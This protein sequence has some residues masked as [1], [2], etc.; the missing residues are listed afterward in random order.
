M[1]TDAPETKARLELK[2]EA[3]PAFSLGGE[4]ACE[5][6]TERACPSVLRS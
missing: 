5:W 6:R 2:V 1:L 3:M 4:E